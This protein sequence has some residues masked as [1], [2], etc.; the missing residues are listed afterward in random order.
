MGK[1]DDGRVRRLERGPARTSRTQRLQPRDVGGVTILVSGPGAARVADLFAS[2]VPRLAD[3]DRGSLGGLV[4]VEVDPA[5]EAKRKALAGNWAFATS[6]G[7]TG[8]ILLRTE[9]EHL[10]DNALAFLIAHEAAHLVHDGR[11]EPDHT[12]AD[13]ER[14]AASWG[15]PTI[16]ETW[17]A[18]RD[19]WAHVPVA[20]R[21][22]IPAWGE[23][24]GMTSESSSERFR[25]LDE[26][27][28]SP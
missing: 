17:Q 26:P 3:S 23:S 11:G 13:A 2:L 28:E 15:G 6:I 5:S 7:G 20:E 18:F 8:T 1:H 25:P 9:I 4:L 10:P 14:L 19:S 21:D 22:G 12:E 27:G 24:R 16:D